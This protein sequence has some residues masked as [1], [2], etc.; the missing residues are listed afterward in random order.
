MPNN[1]CE[2]DGEDRHI[3]Y[4]LRNIDANAPHEMCTVSASDHEP[5]FP[6][7]DMTKRLPKEPKIS[8]ILI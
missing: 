7:L 6:M 1:D 4:F 3:T 2:N 5:G 8:L